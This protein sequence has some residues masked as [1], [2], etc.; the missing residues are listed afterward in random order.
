MN[1]ETMLVYRNAN[2]TFTMNWHLS[3]AVKS[4]TMADTVVPFITYDFWVR[5]T[6]LALPLFFRGLELTFQR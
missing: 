4:A 1:T 3:K 2:N 6:L 5:L